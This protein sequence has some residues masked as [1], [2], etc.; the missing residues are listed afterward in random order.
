MGQIDVFVYEHKR[1]GIEHT[2][3]PLAQIFK[4]YKKPLTSWFNQKKQ[5]CLLRVKGIQ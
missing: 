5:L 1:S 2:T 4:K 3:G